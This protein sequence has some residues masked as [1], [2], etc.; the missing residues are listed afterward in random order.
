MELTGAKI[1]IESLKREGAEVI[2]GLPGGAILPTFDAL[3]DAGLKFILVRHEQGAAH[4]ADGAGA[5]REITASAT[6]SQEI[7]R[8]RGVAQRCA[9]A[10]RAAASRSARNAVR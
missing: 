1:M 7:D 10:R 5:C 2:F 9:A 4:M 6:R 8:R 3:Y